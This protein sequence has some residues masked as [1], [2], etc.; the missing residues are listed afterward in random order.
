[1]REATNLE[2]DPNEPN[3]KIKLVSKKIIMERLG[4]ESTNIVD[5]AA[6]TLTEEDP[7][8]MEDPT[9]QKK[10]LIRQLMHMD[11]PESTPDEYDP[12]TYF[13]DLEDILE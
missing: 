7:D 4:G 3:N 10:R 1:M 6:L 5:A 13:T 9:V 11:D 12:L 8:L 2:L